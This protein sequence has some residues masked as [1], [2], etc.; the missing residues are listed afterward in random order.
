M[1]RLRLMNVA[2]ALTLCTAALSAAAALSSRYEEWRNGPAQWIMTSDEMRA[3]KSVKSDQQAIDFIDLFW[4]RRD[5]TPGTPQNEYRSEYEAR[6]LTADRLFS[7]Q[8][9]RGSMTDRGRVTIVLGQPSTGMSEAGYTTSAGGITGMSGSGRQA[10]ERIEW[11]WNKDKAAAFGMPKVQ[12]VFLQDPTSGRIRRD[13]QRTDFSIANAAAVKRSIVNADLKQVPSWA[14]RGGLEPTALTVM[15]TPAPAASAPAAPT[16]PG[17][18]AM[19][20]TIVFP[21]TK[22]EPKGITRLTLA[23]NIYQVDTETKEDPFTKIAAAETFRPGEELGWAAQYCGA[24]AE[25]PT[26]RF[27]VRLTGK[28]AGEEIDRAAA[29]DELVPDRIRALGGCYMLRGA[30]PLEGMSPGSYEL[31]VA[32]T[33]PATRSESV[34][35]KSFRIE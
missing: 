17:K 33:D 19:E 32:I 2:V 25:E 23:R 29:P 18:V 35:R 9:R 4:A 31:H 1:T 7:D 30:V 13:V 24:S 10:G 22:M 27:T 8:G 15:A 6:V 11:V 28:A 5:P 20:R 34:L 12:V 16:K 14:L 3:W 26:L 21:E